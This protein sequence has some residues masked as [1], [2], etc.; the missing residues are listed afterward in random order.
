MTKNSDS[1]NTEQNTFNLATLVDHFNSSHQEDNQMS[2]VSHSEN[3][4]DDDISL[5][6]EYTD[7]RNHTTSKGLYL[8]TASKIAYANEALINNSLANLIAT[9]NIHITTDGM[10]YFTD[11]VTG[12]MH[13]LK[14]NGMCIRFCDLIDPKNYKSL[15]YLLHEMGRVHD[16][17]LIHI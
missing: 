10:H 15:L 17:S 14:R 12:E 6:T 3:H 11:I 7:K 2:K 8:S 16:L 9:Y 13:A 5:R 4:N 1:N